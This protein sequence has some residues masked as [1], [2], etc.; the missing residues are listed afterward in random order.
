MDVPSV[1]HS[2]PY[3]TD[4]PSRLAFVAILFPILVIVIEDMLQ[5]PR[6]SRL[7]A[8][9]TPV[10]PELLALEDENVKAERERVIS[11]NYRK[12]IIYVLWCLERWLI[13]FRRMVDLDLTLRS[14]WTCN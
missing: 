12:Q 2:E 3:P 4:I 11:L 7:M 13:K 6:F 8:N 1:P 5:S 14:I 10:P 9:K